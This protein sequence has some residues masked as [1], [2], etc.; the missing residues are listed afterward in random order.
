MNDQ[1]LVDTH[2]QNTDQHE[3]ALADPGI[4]A[5]ANRAEKLVAALKIIRGAVLKLTNERDWE[6]LGEKPYLN[7]GG[8]K[9]V[10]SAFGVSWQ[11]DVPIREDYDDGHFD[12]MVSGTFKFRGT[13]QDETGTRSS[14]DDF[15]S[16]KYGASI[17]PSEIDR[18][19]VKKAA[20]TNCI[21][22]GVKSV[23]ALKNFTWD[24]LQ[25]AGISKEKL[26]SVDY[27][28]SA[29][30]PNAA[31]KM[32]N[33]G[34]T[35]CKGKPMD[36]PS[37][38]LEDLRWYL[39][40]AKKSILNP[41]KASWKQT[42]E[43]LARNIEAEIAQ[44]LAAQTAQ[45]AQAEEPTQE[46]EQAPEEQGEGPT[47]QKVA[48][49]MRLCEQQEVAISLMNLAMQEGYSAEDTKMLQ[50]VFAATKKRLKF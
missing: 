17:P 15:F 14:K 5:I 27:S 25:A 20:V 16:K 9:K 18:N 38:T 49:E 46:D 48:Q 23:L 7:E 33:Y 1:E 40:G 50:G 44:R 36:D 45:A 34:R 3:M 35:H 31:P 21:G 24:E 26:A 8:A 43:R 37:V 47:A 6:N 22:R 42:N 4:L 28:K 10:G 13:E 29:A 30:G 19:D 11:L 32:P 41:E 2:T 12:Y 39:D